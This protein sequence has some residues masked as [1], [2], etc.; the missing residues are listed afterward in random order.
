MQFAVIHTARKEQSGQHRQHSVAGKDH[1][2]G[3]AQNHQIPRKAQ[4]TQRQQY[5]IARQRR[6]QA[7]R[8][9][10]GIGALSAQQR[11]EHHHAQ[12]LHGA[13]HG[14]EQGVAG[15]PALAAE[16][17]LEKVDDKV[18]GQIQRAVDKYNGGHHNHG[19]IVA[20]KGGEHLPDAGNPG[21]RSGFFPEEQAAKHLGNHKAAGHQQRHRFEALPLAA[22]AKHTHQQHGKHGDN[23]AAHARAGPSYHRKALPLCRGAGD[24]G[25]HGPVGNV[26]HGIGHAPENIDRREIDHQRGALYGG[27]G[28]QGVEHHRVQQGAAEQP[29]PESPPPGAGFCH[30]HPHEGVVHRV[31]D[32][33]NHQDQAHKGGGQ[34]QH[35]L[36]IVHHIRGGQGV[37]HILAHG[38]DAEGGFLFR[39]Q[40]HWGTSL[41]KMVK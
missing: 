31:K 12:N 22:A 14:T 38:T 25:D 23:G 11:V 2:A 32:S 6:H 21:L 9:H 34:A 16:I 40:F 1:R 5:P 37:H 4:Q 35:I 8:E 36:I 20:E 15:F 29:G 10:L 19:L 18:K 13:A 24:G 39:V 3:D 7:D 17:I 27:S 26:H 33:G 30:K 28:K 41:R